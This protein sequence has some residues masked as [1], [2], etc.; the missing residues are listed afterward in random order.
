MKTPARASLRLGLVFAVVASFSLGSGRAAADDLAK[1]KKFFKQA[2]AAFST[3]KFEK[4]LDLYQKAFA[5]KPLAGFHF[6]MGQCLRELKQHEKAIEEFQL[7]LKESKKAPKFA[8]EAKRLIGLS[9]EDI[10]KAKEA[11][12]PAPKPVVAPEPAP[13]PPPPRPLEAKK[14]TKLPP[15]YF[16]IGVGVTGALVLT[17]V[18]TGGVALSKSSSFKDPSTQASDLQGLK[19]SGEALRTTSDVMLALGLVSAAATTA[20]FF[21]TDFKAGSP[22]KVDTEVNE[23]SAAPIKGGGLVQIGGRF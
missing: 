7:Y 22:S 11:A 15:L 16:Y 2:E 18:I 5:K 12:K 4:A 9:Q 13:A 20:L 8:D 6:N 3:G 23:V 19:D 10:R 21:F 1:A 14:R 17:T